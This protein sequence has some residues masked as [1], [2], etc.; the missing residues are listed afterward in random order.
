MFVE[1]VF[2]SQ[3]T[4]P[5][6]LTLACASSE[7]WVNF[8]GYWGIWREYLKGK[9]SKYHSSDS[10]RAGIRPLNINPNNSF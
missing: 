9:A 10:I 7:S 1:T 5:F 4:V 3:I 8:G 2:K 6:V